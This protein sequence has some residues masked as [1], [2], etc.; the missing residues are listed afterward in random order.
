MK[1][2]R[3]FRNWFVGWCWVAAALSLPVGAGEEPNVPH[4]VTDLRRQ[5]QGE[6]IE[7]IY[8]SMTSVSSVDLDSLIDNLERLTIPAQPTKVSAEAGSSAS[9][10]SPSKAAS[11]QTAEPM[12]ASLSS[13]EKKGVLEAGKQAADSG[14]EA[15]K[16][17]WLE[18][19]DEI[20]EPVEPMAL[21][22]ALFRC[23]EYGRAE[24][25]YRLAAEQI[26]SPSEPD[27][28]WA[29]F[30]RANCLRHSQPQQA[31]QVYE[32][33]LKQ[34]PASRWSSAAKAAT[35]TL[36]WYETMESSFLKRIVSEPNS[37]PE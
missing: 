34:V 15:A 3:T 37:L 16:K 22:D 5:I 25:F 6:L 2:C 18:R 11:P 28:Q 31:R 20:A 12:A 4:S 36:Q 8:L 10:A 26:G 14:E 13:A 29:V 17:K 32:E 1:R 35:E 27:W 21:A 9:K 19:I 7:P 33:L 23:G 30:Q 24:R